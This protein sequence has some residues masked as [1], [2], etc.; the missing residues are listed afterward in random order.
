M[1][2]LL[3]VRNAQVSICGACADS[4]SDAS[5][6]KEIH[7][8]GGGYNKSVFYDH[9]STGGT[10][11]P[12]CFNMTNPKDH[13]ARRKLLARGFSQRYLRD[14]W[15]HAVKDKVDLAVRRIKEE[16]SKGNVDIL[17]WWM[18]MASEFIASMSLSSTACFTDLHDSRRICSSHV[19]R[20]L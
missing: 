20:I 4:P 8:I 6:F 7:R 19:R 12:G 17:K 11:R 5:A 10:G 15:E 2:L 9:L 14:T 3:Q 16:A 18:F 1:K 13:A